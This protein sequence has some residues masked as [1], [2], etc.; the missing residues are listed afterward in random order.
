MREE[1]GD[2]QRLL[3]DAQG[4]GSLRLTASAK[5][6]HSKEDFAAKIAALEKRVAELEGEG[7]EQ[8]EGVGSDSGNTVGA[9][10]LRENAQLRMRVN[11]LEHRLYQGMK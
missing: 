2:R 6:A 7:E 5:P 8:A 10:V 3:E 11:Q 1:V 9:Q 4:S